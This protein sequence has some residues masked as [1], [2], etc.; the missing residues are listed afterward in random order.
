MSYVTDETQAFQVKHLDTSI[1]GGKIAMK[2]RD[3]LLCVRN[4]IG[5]VNYQIS[6]RSKCP[7]SC[8]LNKNL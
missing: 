2:C 6:D 8:C 3:I 4:H 1:E 7:K 5:Y